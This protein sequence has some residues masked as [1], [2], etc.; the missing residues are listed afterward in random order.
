MLCILFVSV[1]HHD[2]ASLSM[3]SQ[4]DLD[5][6]EHGLPPVMRCTGQIVGEWKV[7]DG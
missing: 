2:H 1:Y 7:V 4:H 5:V 3:S 6:D